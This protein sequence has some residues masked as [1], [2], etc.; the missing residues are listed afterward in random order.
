MSITSTAKS[1]MRKIVS[2][3]IGASVS[4]ASKI[5]T[6]EELGS[7]VISK[8]GTPIGIVTERDIL[9]K[10]VSPGLKPVDVSVREV[11][12]SPLVTIIGETGIAEALGIMSDKNI[13]RLLVTEGDKVVGIITEMDLLK[14]IRDTYADILTV[15]MNALKLSGKK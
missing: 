11:M 9:R 15:I 10:V 12:S 7:I 8:D 6:R 3:D 2:I 14:A 5:M 4:E 1:I 13:R